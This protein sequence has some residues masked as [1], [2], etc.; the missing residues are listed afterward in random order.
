MALVWQYHWAKQ[1]HFR[2]A[3]R[4]TTGNMVLQIHFRFAHRWT[5]GSAGLQVHFQ[6]THLWTTDSVGLHIHF[7]SAH[8]F[9]GQLVV[10]AASPFPV[11]ASM[12]IA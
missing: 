12:G 4:W 7:R 5:T 1:F 8:R 6:S 9:G 3:H 11:C 2:L 10:Q